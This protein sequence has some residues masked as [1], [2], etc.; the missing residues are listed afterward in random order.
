MK[1]GILTL[2][3]N[4]NIGNRLQ[5]YALQQ[6]L[7]RYADEVITIR[8][9][10]ALSSL[11][12]RLRRGSPLA[13]SMW[14][15]TLLGEK[16]K[17]RMLRFNQTY[18]HMSK[19]QYWFNRPCTS[20]HPE[21]VCDLYC[22]GS[23]QVWNPNLGRTSSFSYLSFAP[24]NRTFSYAASFGIEQIP[25]E[26]A[27]AIREGLQ[28][29]RYLSV[30]ETAG[31]KIIK[32]LTGRRNVEVLP[33]P[34]L[35][36]TPE[37]WEK[38][39]RKPKRPLPQQYLLTYFLGDLS[40]EQRERVAQMAA[41]N[42]WDVVALMGQDSPWQDIG[43]EEFL[44]LIRHAQLVCT[45]SFHGSVFSFLYQRPVMIFDRKGDGS[46]M[47]SRLDTFTEMYSLTDCRVRENNLPRLPL[48]PDYSAGFAALPRERAKATAFL[49][50]VFQAEAGK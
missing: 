1:V 12:D 17:A 41:D 25:K 40:S 35:L 50:K 4:R 37:E 5:N 9:K 39:A 46:T 11:A 29:I 8:N 24:Q 20:L 2:Y 33:D 44:Y 15:N 31:K 36:L 28:H 16:R 42:N 21:D 49:D 45:D 14:L 26:H 27:T 47:G 34:T 32:M 22:V 18:L 48:R 30:R 6:V 19:G 43:P 13:E 38:I 3:D 10:P 23:D 7:L